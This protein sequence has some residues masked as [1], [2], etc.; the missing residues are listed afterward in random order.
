[1]VSCYGPFRVLVSWRKVDW[2]Q[3]RWCGLVIN[4]VTGV[5]RYIWF[6]R[7]VKHF[8]AQPIACTS[9]RSELVC[10][11]NM[12]LWK[13]RCWGH[14][15]GL[16]QIFWVQKWGTH[17]QTINHVSDHSVSC[18]LGGGVQTETIRFPSKDPS[19]FQCHFIYFPT[20][21]PLLSLGPQ[22]LSDATCLLQQWKKTKQTR[23]KSNH[24]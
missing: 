16:L 23:I 14:R 11:L 10:K 6:V 8:F 15:K 5:A 4:Y 20:A 1:M 12:R 17:Q 2:M 22:M 7:N 21:C 24:V 13:R 18:G 9:G 3:R 19:R